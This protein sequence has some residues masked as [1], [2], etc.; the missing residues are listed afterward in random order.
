[1]PHKS[2]LIF[3]LAALAV[4]G[5]LAHWVW[6]GDDAAVSTPTPADI[7]EKSADTVKD[8]SQWQNLANTKPTRSAGENSGEGDP[9]PTGEVSADAVGI[10]RILQGVNLDANGRLVV[11]ALLQGTL[12]MGF[13]ELGPNPSQADLAKLQK[14]IRAKLPGLAGEEAARILEDYARFRVAEAELNEQTVKQSPA[15]SYEKLA[16]LRRS[17]LGA[18]VAEKLYAVEETNA[19]HMLASM[20]IQMNPNLTDEQKRVQQNALQEKL[21]DRQLALGLMKPDEAA[22]EKVHLLRE[23]GASSADIYSARRAIMGAEGASEQAAADREEAKW[24]SRFNGYWQARRYVM[25]AGLDEGERQRQIEQLLDQYF[26]PEER[27]RA[28]ITSSEREVREAK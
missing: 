2:V 20:A 14:S 4:I 19:R 22:A 25:Q 26:T 17:Y 5:G 13:D 24:Q 1:M 3:C 27:E 23:R 11:D 7:Q 21:N 16:R 18:E 8:K 12:E 15:D 28:R 10:D 9:R 6:S